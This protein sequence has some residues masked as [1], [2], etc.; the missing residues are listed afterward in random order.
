MYTTNG[1]LKSANYDLD[2]DKA[3]QL[4]ERVRR[5]PGGGDA[6]DDVGAA[7]VSFHD[8]GHIFRLPKRIP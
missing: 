8:I 5:V 2:A 6:E 4:T 7:V 1:T 3:I